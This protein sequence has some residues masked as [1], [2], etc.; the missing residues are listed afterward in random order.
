MRVVLAGRQPH[1]AER[2]F[3]V[4]PR[5]LNAAA[6]LVPPQRKAEAEEAA[7][8]AE[9]AREKAKRAKKAQAEGKKKSRRKKPKR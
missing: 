9:K 5:R 8:K 4:R 1:R 6:K 2:S 3:P 7:R